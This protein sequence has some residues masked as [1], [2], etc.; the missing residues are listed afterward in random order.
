M[1]FH[2]SGQILSENGE[3]KINIPFNVWEVCD[4]QG[5]LMISV[6]AM[7][8]SWEC[9]LTPLGKG[10]Y[11]IPVTEQQAEGHMGETFPVVF[12]IL[13]RSPHHTAKRRFMRTDLY[14]HASRGYT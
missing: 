7:G 3:L 1:K 14:R 5:V 6:N 8:L 13:N 2:F 10:Y 11:T 12:E 4:S 9:N